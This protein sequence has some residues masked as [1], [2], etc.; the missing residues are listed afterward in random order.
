MFSFQALPRLDISISKDYSA[1]QQNYCSSAYYSIFIFNPLQLFYGEQ[2][3]GKHLSRPAEA[4]LE[5]KKKRSTSKTI[6]YL[7]LS[8]VLIAIAAAIATAKSS[9][10]LGVASTAPIIIAVGV[11]LLVL[12]GALVI[13]WLVQLVATILGGKGKYY[14]GLTSVTNALI[15][16]SVGAVAA[17]VLSYIPFIGIPLVFLVLAISL[18]M[19]L[20][21][22]YRSVKELF[23]SDMIT[24][25]VVVSVLSLALIIALL[26]TMMSLPS[27]LSMMRFG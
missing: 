8:S 27:W 17:A 16:P 20:A 1:I 19:G 4:I 15:V 21:T 13:G 2:M 6:S 5:S 23:S 7:L 14:E 9:L 10:L 18:S 24:A 22:L 3:V 25:F 12:I 26:G 11:F